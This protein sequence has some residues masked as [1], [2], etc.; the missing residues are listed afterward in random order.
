MI[1]TLVGAT[2]GAASTF[3]KAGKAFAAGSFF[4]FATLGYSIGLVWFGRFSRRLREAGVWTIPD[5]IRRRYGRG[6]EITMGAVMLVAVVAVFGGQVMGMG[7]IFTAVGKSFGLTYTSAI[8]IAGGVIVFYTLVGGLFAVAYTD[9]IQSLIMIIGIGIILPAYVLTQSSSTGSL[10]EFLRPPAGDLLGGLSPLYV[11]SIFLIDIPFCLVD[12][13]LWQRSQAAKTDRIV[14]RSSWVTAG[15]YTYWSLVCVVLGV[16]GSRLIPDVASRFGSADAII[17]ALTITYLPAGLIGFCLAGMM[18]VMMS[19]ASVALLITG[20]TLSNDLVKPLR[21]DL[22][23]KALLAATR[24]TVL[25][26]GILGVFFALWIKNIFDL[27]L[28]AFAVYVSGVFFPVMAALYWEKATRAGAVWSSAAASVVVVALYALDKPFGIEPIMASLS[29]SA[30]LMFAV[31]L[32]TWRPETATLRVLP[33][34]PGADFAGSQ[35]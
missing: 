31:S 8:V 6:M 1:G 14:E 22:S 26:V 5:V 28:L 12:P 18:A 13:S 15:V 33:P 4:F 17:P 23:E 20:T 34:R 9:L 30:V 2:I 24:V 7:A 16:M 25:T 3:G 27:L 11:S 19:T 29:L 21:P 35:D 32:A 10:W